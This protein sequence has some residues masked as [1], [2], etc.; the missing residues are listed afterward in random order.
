MK[1]F[2]MLL[3]GIACYVVFFVT[4]LYAIGFVGNVGVPKAID[5]D[6]TVPLLTAIGINVALLTLFA[7]QHSL[8]ARPFFKRWWTRYVPV[9]A[10]RSTYVLFSSLALIVLFAFW[11][12]LGG[13]VWHITNQSA[14]IAIY[15]VFSLGWA[16]VLVSTF[17]I[18]HF[19]LFG[20][21]QAW[22]YFHGEAY[23][24]L[25]FKTPFLYRFVRHPLYFGI[26][27]A[28]W[29]APVMSVTR[30]L[31]ALIFTLYVIRA[32]DWEENDLLREFGDTYRRYSAKVPKIFPRFFNRKSL[33]PAYK[34][35][36]KK[37]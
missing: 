35:I 5:A 7:V 10:E 30:L 22:L 8:M 21:R 17:L 20:L 3:Y 13:T 16:V 2:T 1:R 23:R 26:L 24:P 18:N 11:E 6:P 4:F 31:F 28:F 27:L 29:S 34:S 37:D 15:T 14:V 25:V 32:I 12:P 36:A 9:A 19:D 33:E